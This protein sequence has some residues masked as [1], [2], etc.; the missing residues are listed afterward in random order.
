MR[1]VEDLPGRQDQDRGRHLVGVEVDLGHVRP[2]SAIAVA[3]AVAVA[4]A[5]AAGGAAVGLPSPPSHHDVG[6]G[7][8]VDDGAAGA[9]AS[10]GEHSALLQGVSVVQHLPQVY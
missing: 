1:G 2:P 8:K 4:A 6:L 10:A 9:S 7:E 5:V 3:V